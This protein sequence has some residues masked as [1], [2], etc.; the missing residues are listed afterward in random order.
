VSGVPEAIRRWYEAV[1]AGDADALVAA[2]DERVE[3]VNPPDAADPGTRVG[4][5]A[6]REALGALLDSFAGYRNEV[7]ETVAAA[8]RVL[9]I[10]RSS[11]RGRESGVP[12]D[13]VH[14]HLFT[15]RNGLVTRFAWFRTPGEARRAAGLDS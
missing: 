7:I 2:C 3:Y 4:H 11:G 10:E 15:V 6:L 13:A 9:V 5:A 1:N 14:G 12:F 8:D